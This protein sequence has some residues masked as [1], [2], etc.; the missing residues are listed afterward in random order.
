MEK[1]QTFAFILIGVILVV[2][3]YINSP[4]PPENLPQSADSTIVE[5]QKPV[6]E[7]E[8][9]AIAIPEEV[10]SIPDSVVPGQSAKKEKIITI[11]TDL[12]RVEFTTKGARLK[13]YFL[14][15]HQTWYNSSLPEDAPFYKKYVQL[16]N[17]QKDGGDLNVIFVTKGG[18]KINTKN[19]V[20]DTD[21][22]E[23]YYK[24][25]AGDSLQV[26]FSL[27][28]G[29]GRSVNKKFMFRGDDYMAALD[30][31]MVNMKN[32]ISGVNYDIAWENGINFVEKNSVDEANYSSSS[33]YSGEEQIVIDATSPDEIEK[34]ELN[35]K[36]DW[37]A[38]RNKYFAMILAPQ[39][40]NS[41]WSAYLEGEH[42]KD[43]AYGD[44]E[45]YY[46]SLGVPLK[47][48]SSQVNK[49]DFYVGPMDYNILDSYGNSYEKLYD[50]GSFM[51][52]K[53]IIRPISEYILLPFFKFLHMFIPNYG[54]VIIVFSIFI[55]IVLYPLT[56]QSYKSMK[57]MQQLQPKIKAMKD[58]YPDDPQRVQKE[59]MALYS[60][61]GVSPLGGCL[62]MVFQMPILIALFSLFNV[63]IAIRGEPFILWIDNLA[64]PDVIFHLPFTL[65]L[66]GVSAVSGLA[67]LLGVT[68][69]FQQSMTMKDPS[70]KAMVYIMPVMFTFLFMGFPSGLNL[71]YFM[72]NLLSI[73]QQWLVN[74]SKTDGELVPVD[75]KKRKKGF[76]AKLMEQAE[77][78]ANS[79]KK[80][81]QPRKKRK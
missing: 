3:L 7:E 46:I 61:Y 29:E 52:L 30:I 37:I 11:E 17:T 14:K 51:G 54:W 28:F 9:P 41:D 40:P 25:D 39:D 20:F 45:Y 53:F 73:I 16:I 27:D 13:R 77:A 23:Y 75:P 72:F 55:K 56:K 22:K 63:T 50:F 34:K 32:V 19:L 35:G 15:E 47:N 4:E 21:L 33:V 70:Q 24:V 67:L 44:R 6:V 48:K 42:V 31:E 49:F 5:N 78:Q 76:M 69:F 62:P 64:A 66:F 81:N 8:K 2:W 36:I 79:Q 68:M 38:V 1:N 80:G 12:A 58:Q 26:E 71:Y 60:K 57:R 59:T 10:T 43:K 65:P 18:Q 74:K